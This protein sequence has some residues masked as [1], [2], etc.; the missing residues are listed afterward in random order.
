MI[1]TKYLWNSAY[2]VKFDTQRIF[3]YFLENMHAFGFSAVSKLP[4]WWRLLG[5]ISWGQNPRESKAQTVHNFY[6]HLS[7]LSESWTRKSNI[8]ILLVLDQYLEFRCMYVYFIFVCARVSK[9]KKQTSWEILTIEILG[10]G[11]PKGKCLVILIQW[12]KS[13]GLDHLNAFV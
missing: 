10:N 5:P 13:D 1:C 8:V 4:L 6:A 3:N 2:I 12:M 7:R 11:C 9:P